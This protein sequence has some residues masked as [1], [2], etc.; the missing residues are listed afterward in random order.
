[1]DGLEAL[2]GELQQQARLADACASRRR[3]Q[4]QP[5]GAKPV[6]DR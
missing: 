6:S 4:Q 3:Q 2:V 5:S 1:V